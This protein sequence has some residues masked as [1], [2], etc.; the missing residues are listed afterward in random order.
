MRTRTLLALALGCAVAIMVAGAVFLLQLAGRDDPPPPAPFG[1]PVMVGDMA[2]TVLHVTERDGRLSI[3]VRLGGVDD[4]DGG[5]A[6]RLIASGRPAPPI[7]PVDGEPCAAT[8]VA[9]ANCFL[10]FDVSGA[11]GRSRVLFY[12]R[13]DDQARWLAEDDTVASR[14]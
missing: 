12:D 7:A 5:T 11:D 4:A 6:F 14:E 2:V 3:E 10:A 8:A 9:P 1:E 13:G